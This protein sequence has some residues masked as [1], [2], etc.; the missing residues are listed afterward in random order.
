[1]RA[2][3]VKVNSGTRC[4]LCF[5]FFFAQNVIIP[6]FCFCVF[7]Q[8][9]PKTNFNC[10]NDFGSFFTQDIPIPAVLTSHG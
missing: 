7:C 2:R 4:E 1:M 6:S 5:F 8:A 9:N 3:L 10:L